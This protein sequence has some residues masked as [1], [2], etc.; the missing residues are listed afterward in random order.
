MRQLALL[1]LAAL[2]CPA[3]LCAGPIYGVIFFNGSAVRGASI[4]VSCGGPAG[5][6][7]TL[8][9]GSYRINVPREGRCIFTVSSGSFGQASAEVVL[10]SGAVQYNFAVVRGGGGFE[11][12]RQ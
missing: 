9:D 3:L 8:D 2:L 4:T 5:G 7:S 1:C 10:S 6:G 11:L 12:R